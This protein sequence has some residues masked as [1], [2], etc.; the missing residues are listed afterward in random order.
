MIP[1]KKSDIDVKSFF[2]YIGVFYLN[3]WA[4]IL[5]VTPNIHPMSFFRTFTVALLSFIVGITS[6]ALFK[7]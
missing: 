3:M 5:W 2:A 7:K 1:F 6:K 4:I